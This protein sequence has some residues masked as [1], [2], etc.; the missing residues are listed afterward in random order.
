MLLYTTRLIIIAFIIILSMHWLY[1]YNQLDICLA[2][3]TSKSCGAAGFE[4]A[5]FSHHP[6]YWTQL[7][8][9]F[10][11]KN[12]LPNPPEANM[13]IVIFSSFVA[14]VITSAVSLLL[15]P[16]FKL[17]HLPT[18]VVPGNRCPILA[19]GREK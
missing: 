10:I 17:L 15:Q 3:K 8:Q 2:L 12:C 13:N 6:C 7:P 18:A 5:Y 1:P 19:Y 9:G 14:C 4:F 11:S 16:V